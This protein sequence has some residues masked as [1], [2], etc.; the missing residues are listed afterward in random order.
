MFLSNP[1]VAELEPYTPGL[2]RE[3]VSLKYGV[4]IDDVAKL[5]SAENPLGPSPLAKVAVE[6]AL[7]RIDLYPEWTA[8]PLREKIAQTYDVHPDQVVCGAGETEV[9]SWVIRVFAESDGKLL[10][11]SPTFP[12]YHLFAR[13]EG[14]QCVFVPMGGDFDFHLDRFIE[15]I[16]GDVRVVFLTRPHSPTGKLLDDAA[17]RRVCEAAGERLVVL[18]EAYIHFTETAGGIHL[19]EDFDNL[20]VLRTF[21]KAYGLAGLRVGFGITRS[22][23]ALPMLAV[24]PTWNMGQL[25]VAGGIAA[26]DDHQHVSRTVSM[27]VEMRDYVADRLG[28]L[29]SFRMIAGSRSN[30]F[31]LE[32]L[33]TTLDSTKVFNGLLERGVIVKDCSVSFHGLGHRYMRIDVSLRKHMDRLVDALAEIEP[34]A[35]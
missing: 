19:V 23:I 21:S 13:A 14:R 34:R 2:S 24:K 15:H 28:A 7:G 26:L 10:M 16:A 20:I 30:F 27:I 33:D 9:L 22:H 17:V 32:I 1:A 35:G 18:D 25:Q 8:A 12:I 29:N 6:A 31:L 3:F 11:H 4:P 5:G